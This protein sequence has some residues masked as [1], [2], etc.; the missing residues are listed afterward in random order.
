MRTLASIALALPVLVALTPVRL[1]AAAAPPPTLT[2]AYEAPHWLVIQGA[3]L[4][5]GEI[6]VNYLE[7]YC[8]AGSTDADWV[9]HTVIPHRV[10]LLSLSDD[11]KTLR[12]RD[13][14]ADGVS[15]EHTITARDD[16]VD[17]RLVARNPGAARS[18]AHWSQPCVRLGDFTGFDAD[19]RDIDDYLPKCFIFLN[20]R[21]TRLTEVQPWAT[22]ARYTPGQVWCPH[23]VPRTDVNPR[24]LSSLVPDNGLIGAF[25]G[26]ERLLFATAWEPYQELFQGV[27]RCLHSDFRLGGLEPGETRRI[28]GK[29]YVVANDVP[30]LL[31]R[32]A[33]D[34]PEHQVG[35]PGG[36]TEI[37]PGSGAAGPSDPVAACRI[38]VMEQGSGWPVP[39]VG[40]RTTHNVRFV[41]DNAGIIAFDLPELMGKECWFFVEGHGYG[42]PAD[43]FG[44][45]GVRL[46]P[47]PGGEATVEVQR[48]LP[49]KRLGRITGGGI[50]GESQRFGLESGW[51]DQ[52]LLGCDSV[53][54][55]VHNGRLFW[56][57]GD[58]AVAK[59]PLG[60]FHMA[61]ATTG[62]RPLQSFEPPVRLR[63]DYF[64]DEK[65]D[66][67][68][69]ARMPGD[70]PT[71]ISGYVSLP[72]QDGVSRLA[73][74]YVKIEHQLSPY[75]TGLCVWDE[76]EQRFVNH[77]VLWK[78]TREEPEPPRTPDGH[79][80]FWQDESGRSWVLFGDPFPRLRCEATF[81]AWE[82]PDAWEML[83][84]QAKVRST[85]GGREITPHRG[86]IAWNGYRRR[87]VTVFTE[88]A[89]KPSF[90]GEI[91][92]AESDAPTGPWGAAVKV[93]TH[94]NYT[95][96]NP[97]LHPELTGGE[98]PILL[99]EGTFTRQF[100]D[101]PETWPRHDY[102]Q[103]LYRLDLDD[104]AL[105]G[106]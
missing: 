43:G 102:N 21:L 105:T 38:N 61:S 103:V 52:G 80:T 60:L 20:G 6:R 95:F 92:Y 14:L 56:A 10:E 66:V 27:I 29:I 97:R 70:G 48:E 22:E 99:F 82:N 32:Y 37:Q 63:Y 76:Q 54:I 79:P 41:S 72:D 50:F 59:Y 18:E 1:P 69:V 81:E 11:R 83:E 73:A 40:L 16:E 44:Y 34:F 65:G 87:W 49:A 96:Y 4:P 45:R 19:G 2:L 30:A 88:L 98:S 57:W 91:W 55:A 53:Q 47:T 67:R 7:A 74:T 9:Q 75:E 28:R 5:G 46:T 85:D 31:A 12:L 93:V 36:A 101:H 58:S 26:D 104:P 86:S 89:G 78:K 64:R 68:V 106:R 17:F 71:W 51:E 100:A 13:T 3:H 90:L 35:Q 15:V 94:A 24:P 42:V 8:R 77:R 33:R 84:P 62:L 25:S 23:D 39:M